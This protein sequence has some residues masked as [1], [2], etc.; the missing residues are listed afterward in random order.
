[1]SVGEGEGR[2]W[3]EVDLLGIGCALPFVAAETLPLAARALGAAE[4]AVLA[5]WAEEEG[6]VG[7]R[8][9][10]RRVRCV[11]RAEEPGGDGGGGGE[12]SEE[13]AARPAARR[14]R[15]ENEMSERRARG[16][17][18]LSPGAWWTGSLA[19][20]VEG[21]EPLAYFQLERHD[22]GAAEEGRSEV[23]CSD[24]VVP[25]TEVD[26]VLA[27]LAGVVSQARRDGVL[28]SA[29]VSG[30]ASSP[31]GGGSAE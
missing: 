11:A 6:V 16:A 20:P 4:W 15:Y 23:A 2:D 5:W 14:A 29:P 17:V 18:P 25:A 28:P 3:V 7:Y 13:R 21:G 24:F 12:R 27:L 30:A 10:P 22:T 26:A 1:M 19:V 9:V 31:P 8:G